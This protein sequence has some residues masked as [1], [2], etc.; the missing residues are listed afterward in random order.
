MLFVNIRQISSTINDRLKQISTNFA[1]SNFRHILT[2]FDKSHL[3]TTKFD[4]TH[5]RNSDNSTKFVCFQH[6]ST[7]QKN[8]FDK[9]RQII[10]FYDNESCRL[11]GMIV[12]TCRLS[13]IFDKI[14]IIMFYFFISIM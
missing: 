1:L 4:K 9:I 13:K 12:G 6:S 7:I 2:N 3:S 14:P 5:F 11:M 8:L 10:Q